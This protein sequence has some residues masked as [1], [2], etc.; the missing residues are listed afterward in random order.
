MTADPRHMANL[1]PDSPHEGTGEVHTPTP[2][3]AVT[4]T[5]ESR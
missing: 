1:E 4:G 3:R 5:A 2:G